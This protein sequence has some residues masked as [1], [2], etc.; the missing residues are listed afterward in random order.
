M[1]ILSLSPDRERGRGQTLRPG[2]RLGL[3]QGA[4]GNLSGG[5]VARHA[6]DL[7]RAG[8]QGVTVHS[9]PTP[10][11]VS[12]WQPSAGPRRRSIWAFGAHRLGQPLARWPQDTAAGSRATVAQRPH[13]HGEEGAFWHPVAWRAERL[14]DSG[15]YVA[16]GLAADGRPI[17]HAAKAVPCPP[18]LEGHVQYQ[19]VA[20]RRRLALTMLGMLL[21]VGCG[22]DSDSVTTPTG[23]TP[24]QTLTVGSTVTITQTGQY[25]LPAGSYSMRIEC[26]GSVQY[27]I[28]A[29]SF[30]ASGT[31][32]G[33]GTNTVG[34]I[35]GPGTV[36]FTVS[37]G[38]VRVTLE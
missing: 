20:A 9:R 4:R 18:R 7:R 6:P 35:V 36:D 3:L 25:R 29:G 14:R 28:R 37:S 21:Y 2:D 15:T 24:G 10:R 12:V 30:S 38:R 23:T 32:S 33:G 17:V 5:L 16:R 13:K 19:A 1:A 22:S 31:C 11:C 8:L 26:D 34:I 27:A